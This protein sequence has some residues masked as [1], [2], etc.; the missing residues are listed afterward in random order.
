MTGRQ[1][2]FASLIIVG[3]LAVI[4]WGFRPTD[5]PFDVA[6]P[7]TTTTAQTTPTTTTTT[8]APST[9]TPEPTTTTTTAEQRLEEVREIIQDRWHTWLNSIYKRDDVQLWSVAGT[10]ARH[11]TGLAAFDTLTF[12]EPPIPDGVVIERLEIL[13]DR[14]DCLVVD[15]ELNV[16][17]SRGTEQ[18]FASIVSVLWPDERYGYRFATHWVSPGDLWL[19]DCDKLVRDVTP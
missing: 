5:D 3:L 4:W 2:F 15:T 12:V 19:D 1:W 7:E 16:T 6:F 11:E 10:F 9:T 14:P 18:G 17:Q 13:L 8:S